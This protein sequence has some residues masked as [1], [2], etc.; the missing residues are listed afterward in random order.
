KALADAIAESDAWSL[1]G[2]GD[3]VAAVDND[4]I[5]DKISYISTGGGAFLE[6]VEGKTLPAVAAMEER[7]AEG[8]TQKLDSRGRWRGWPPETVRSMYAALRPSGMYLRGVLGGQPRCQPKQAP[9]SAAKQNL[10]LKKSTKETTHGPDFAA[11]TSGPRRRAWL[12][13]ASL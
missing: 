6:L 4:G 1:A 10:N 7:G 11:A 3:T 13:C 5:A 8:T 9:K 2:G 12:R